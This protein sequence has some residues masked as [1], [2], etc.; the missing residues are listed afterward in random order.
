VLSLVPE[1]PRFNY[2]KDRF[3]EAKENL[4]VVAE[5]NGVKNFNKQ[6]F[7]FDTEHELETI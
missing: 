4:E 5:V 7:K 2:S 1:S 3:D 6:N